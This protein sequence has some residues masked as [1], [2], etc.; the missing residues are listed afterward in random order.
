[1]EPTGGGGE[2]DRIDPRGCLY[3]AVRLAGCIGSLY[4]LMFLAIL[5]AAAVSL[6]FFR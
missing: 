2:E 6:L 1:V 5:L 3:S 4:V